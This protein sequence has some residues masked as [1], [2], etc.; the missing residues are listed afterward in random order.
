MSDILV[1][2][3]CT[4]G[5]GTPLTET[6]WWFVCGQARGRDC[7]EYQVKQLAAVLFGCVSSSGCTK[8]YQCAVSMSCYPHLLPGS[9]KNTCGHELIRNIVSVCPPLRSPIRLLYCLFCTFSLLTPSLYWNLKVEC[10]GLH[11]VPPLRFQID[12][13]TRP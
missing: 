2:L 7:V 5:R 6:V 11:P 13:D 8:L 10:S 3:L 9:P 4:I 1:I 12:S